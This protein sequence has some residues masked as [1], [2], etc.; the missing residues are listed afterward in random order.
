MPVASSQ[1]G[2]DLGGLTSYV[3]SKAEAVDKQNLFGATE[4]EVKREMR[5][6]VK[7]RENPGG[8]PLEKPAYHISINYD[9][10]EEITDEEMLSDMRELLKRRGMGAHQA[11]LA[12]HRDEPHPHVHAAVNRVHPQTDELWR[13]TFD[14]DKNMKV[15]REIEQERGRMT[16]EEDPMRGRIADWK[17]QKEKRTGEK[18]FGTLV[19][20]VAGEEFAE[21]ETWEELQRR[22]AGYPDQGL[23][24]ERKGSGGIIT[25]GEEEAPLSEVATAWSF[26][27]LDERFPDQFRS[28]SH[29]FER[30]DEGE[31][32]G[33]VKSA[34]E[35]REAERGGPDV[36]GGSSGAETE[37]QRDAGRRRKDDR[38]AEESAQIDEGSG[39]DERGV[40]Q[41]PKSKGRNRGSGGRD[42]SDKMDDQDPN[43]DVGGDS[44]DGGVD[45]SDVDRLDIEHAEPAVSPSGYGFERGGETED[46]GGEESETGLSSTEQK[47]PESDRPD[48][49]KGPQESRSGGS[50]PSGSKGGGVSQAGSDLSARGRRLSEMLLNGE[51]EQAVREWAK[52]DNDQQREAW[53]QFGKDR[54]HRLRK[55]VEEQSQSSGQSGSQSQSKGQQS[56]GQSQGGG[57]GKDKEQ[58]KDQSKDQGKGQSQGGQ[59]WGGGRGR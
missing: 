41:H 1:T 6:T 38:G 3:V 45:L 43:R 57:Q 11:V 16:P 53:E 19:K 21:S 30:Q 39:G 13:N 20:E 12:V 28:Y 2:S 32:G 37:G 40:G 27:K 36:E 33:D 24:V 50:R 44:H 5:L 4:R 52:M 34:E 9:E 56:R 10:D 26:N 46:E 58:G 31:R 22:L 51:H 54:Q 14:Y 25:D 29:G 55:A 35:G 47:G 7:H 15:L 59:R 42:Q 49:G 8:R 48:A 23:W 17:H 18:P